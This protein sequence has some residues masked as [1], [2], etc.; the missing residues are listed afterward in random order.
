MSNEPKPCKKFF[1]FKAFEWKFKSIKH[2]RTETG[3]V[4]RRQGEVDVSAE[5]MN[6]SDAWV[7]V[8]PVEVEG[9][10]TECEDFGFRKFKPDLIS[11]SSPMTTS[12]FCH[13]FPFHLKLSRRCSKRNS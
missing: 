12:N 13:N 8:E 5:E 11:S 6:F 7:R 2:V 10:S 4:L 3:V 9:F 1:A